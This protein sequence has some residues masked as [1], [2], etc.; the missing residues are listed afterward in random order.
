MSFAV[1]K[2]ATDVK[3]LVYALVISMKAKLFFHVVKK[4]LNNYVNVAICEQLFRL[5]CHTD[6]VYFFQYASTAYEKMKSKCVFVPILF[7][8]VCLCGCLML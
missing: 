3:A 1:C 5:G 6:S 8:C 7:M 4:A 2:N